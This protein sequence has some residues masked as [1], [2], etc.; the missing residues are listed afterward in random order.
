MIE[1]RLSSSENAVNA[2]KAEIS[3]LKTVTSI[4]ES[5][6]SSYRVHISELH[7][8]LLPI[9]KLHDEVL[10]Q[11]FTY[12]LEKPIDVLNMKHGGIWDLQS[13]CVD[14]RKLVQNTQ[15][16]WR[17]FGAGYLDTSVQRHIS[18]VSIA[19]RVFLCLTCSGTSALTIFLFPSDIFPIHLMEYIGYYCNRWESFETSE[20]IL[21]KAVRETRLKF[22]IQKRGLPQLRQLIFDG[23]DFS[24][25]P[26]PVH[27]FRGA[28]ALEEVVLASTAF[29][30]IGAL[31]W[32]KIRKLVIYWCDNLSADMLIDLLHATP[33][34]EELKFYGHFEPDSMNPKS[35]HIKLPLLHT[36][37]ISGAGSLPMLF[38]P[39]LTTL[40]ISYD[41]QPAHPLFSSVTISRSVIKRLELGS[42]YPGFI[43][44][45]IKDFCGVEELVVSH[46]MRGSFRDSEA[47]QEV[48][49][50]LIRGPDSTMSILPSL[51]K[52][53]L[54]ADILS[55]PD[56]H[57]SLMMDVMRSRS[58]VAA[59]TAHPNVAPLTSLRFREKDKYDRNL[60]VL[61]LEKLGKELG[62]IVT[63]GTRKFG[64]WSNDT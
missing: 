9:R 24:M 39:R 6:L 3:D 54:D 51:Q 8:S 58:R 52:L 4:L 34:L 41:L 13:V 56:G 62:I 57:V 47:I 7:N 18:P 14:W 35:K 11:I 49:Q 25:E 48:L 23:P 64:D 10:V 40:T 21:A 50:D 46:I 38:L 33:L 37:H 59:A 16:L 61:L 15:S 12:V 30:D 28:T 63:S 31:S 22:I 45:L 55:G 42:C 2:I 5:K 53:E 36:I 19:E 43:L 26:F 32:S 27:I 20:D 44:N 60:S 1:D 29:P 17:N